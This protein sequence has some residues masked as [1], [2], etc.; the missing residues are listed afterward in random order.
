MEQICFDFSISLELWNKHFMLFD[1]HMFI[2]RTIVLCRPYHVTCGIC[3]V[4]STLGVHRIHNFQIRP[5]P[6]PNRI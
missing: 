3:H 2:L 6:D 4:R 5:D 1:V